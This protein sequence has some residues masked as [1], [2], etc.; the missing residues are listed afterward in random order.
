MLRDCN[1]L[2][3]PHPYNVHA[4]DPDPLA[5]LPGA[6]FFPR[7]GYNPMDPD[8]RADFFDSIYHSAA[9]VGIN[10]SA[11]IEA[12]IIGRPVFSML[13]E[14]FSGTQEGLVHFHHL[15]PENGG[16]VRIASTI[17]EHV[18][19]LSDRL[20]DPEAARAETQQFIAH[21]IRPH[22]LDRPATPVFVDTIERFAVSSAPAPRPAPAWAYAFRPVVWAGAAA[23]AIGV[24][25]RRP[26]PVSWLLR[27]GQKLTWSTTKRVGRSARLTTHRAAKQWHKTVKP[28]RDFLP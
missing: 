18:H 12:A 9:V 16:C 27:R 2:V 4:W 13:A 1:I 3:R 10:T 6:V 24:W 19:Q 22:G 15:V 25:A 8:N 23:A 21:F 14:E 11:M 28:I 5:D 17:E 7:T 20:R 26:Q